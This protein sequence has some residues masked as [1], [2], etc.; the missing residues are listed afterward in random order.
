M[1]VSRFSSQNDNAPFRRLLPCYR[2]ARFRQ[3]IGPVVYVIALWWLAPDICRR[4][5]A[6]GKV[7]GARRER[8]LKALRSVRRGSTAGGPRLALA[9][10]TE[11]AN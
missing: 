4:A 1:T 7:V 6:L 11:N 8:V 3:R 5:L 2:R 10:T 9:S